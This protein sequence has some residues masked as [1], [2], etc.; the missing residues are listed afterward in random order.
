MDKPTIYIVFRMHKD[1]GFPEEF[2]NAMDHA[3]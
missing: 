2:M 3:L 1:G